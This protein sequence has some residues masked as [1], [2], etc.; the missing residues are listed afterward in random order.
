MPTAFG[1]ESHLSRVQDSIMCCASM[2]SI[3]RGRSPIATDELLSALQADDTESRKNAVEIIQDHGLVSVQEELTRPALVQHEGIQLFHLAVASLE[4]S[5]GASLEIID[6]QRNS[7]EGSSIATFEAAATALNVAML[8][9]GCESIDHILGGGIPVNGGSIVEI[10]GKAGVGK[11]QLA[12]QIALMTTTP[13]HHGGLQC[14]CIYAFIEGRPPIKRM[15]EIERALCS[16]FDI[17]CGTLLDGVVVEAVRSADELLVWSETRL[18]YL[19]RETKARVVV[20][21]SI[22]AVYRPEFKDALSRMKHMAQTSAA[23]KRA[24]ATVQGVCVCVNQVSQKVDNVGFR[25]NFV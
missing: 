6:L 5:H 15:G 2:T 23:L 16:K 9:T 21:D 11:T 1:A 24:T 17:T 22:A 19:L 13:R 12:M 4:V 7:D 10:S 3:Y 18:P 14:H 8:K 25:N 20:I